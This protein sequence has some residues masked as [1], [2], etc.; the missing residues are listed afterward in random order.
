MIADAPIIIRTNAEGGVQFVYHHELTFLLSE[1]SNTVRRASHIEPVNS[2]LRWLFHAIRR[3]AS[4]TGWAA[5]F[6]RRWP[7]LWRI[8]FSLSGGPVLARTFTK[9][10]NALAAEVAWLH[11]HG[12]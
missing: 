5:A 8:N 10:A 3:R 9:R 4:D 7:C 11:A 1:G 12:F 2:V 6:T